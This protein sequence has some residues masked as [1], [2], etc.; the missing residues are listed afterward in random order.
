MSQTTYKSVED[1]MGH[2]DDIKETLDDGEYLTLV[3]SLMEIKNFHQRIYKSLMKNEIQFYKVILQNIY[4]L[5]VEL[6]DDSPS[7]KHIKK[8]T[9]FYL[10][11]EDIPCR[12]NYHFKYF[13][14]LK[15]GTIPIY[16]GKPLYQVGDIIEDDCGE[17][18]LNSVVL[19]ITKVN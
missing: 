3:N 4:S 17:H 5:A 10:R 16:E 9:T 15:Y 18:T 8:R 7:M 11:G 6:E 14:H 19:E 2:L 1:L 12:D 13:N